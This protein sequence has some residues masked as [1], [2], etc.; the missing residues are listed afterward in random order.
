MVND[1]HFVLRQGSGLVGAD[2]LGTSESLDRGQAADYRVLLRHFRHAH[3]KDYRDDGDKSLRYRRNRKADGKHEGIEHAFGVESAVSYQAEHEHEHAD[4]EH[5]LCE[6]P[7]ELGQLFLERGLSFLR[8]GYGGGDLAHLGIHSGAGH[9]H[10][11]ASVDG[12]AAHVAHIFSVAERNVAVVGGF[13]DA[14][15]LFR[16]NGFSGKCGLLYLEACSLYYSSVCGDS[17][18]GF[19]NDD[20]SGDKLLA[21][22]R[23]VFS[24]A[25]DL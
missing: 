22:H 19:E 4:A 16:R 17:V 21:L 15:G 20:I 5:Q 7:A 2:Y 10:S 1:G 14:V 11:A 25:D 3:R 12:N 23:H 9:D 13:K 8:L 18:S 6:Y 24:V